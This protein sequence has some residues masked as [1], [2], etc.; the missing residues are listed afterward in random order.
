MEQFCSKCIHFMHNG[1]N[2]SL[3]K[4]KEGAFLWQGPWR[5][6]RK[7]HKHS[8][9]R[10]I[11]PESGCVGIMKILW[12]SAHWGV[13]AVLMRQVTH[14]TPQGAAADWC[15]VRTIPELRNIWITTRT[16]ISPAD[17]G[18][19][20][21]H[22]QICNF[23]CLH[24]MSSDFRRKFSNKIKLWFLR[25]EVMVA[26]DFGDKRRHFLRVSF[27]FE[28]LLFLC[29]VLTWHTSTSPCSVSCWDGKGHGLPSKSHIPGLHPG[30]RTLRK[31]QARFRHTMAVRCAALDTVDW[32]HHLKERAGH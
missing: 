6:T 8:S 18:W 22:K 9:L 26:L 21:L 23:V 27:L 10:H 19:I 11:H 12:A 14:E 17:S 16:D 15:T 25:W 32:G 5:K 24:N 4:R 13:R 28:G 1:E 30:G 20:I 31:K 3:K 7:V 2:F 29:Q